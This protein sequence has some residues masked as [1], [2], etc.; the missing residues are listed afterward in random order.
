MR[1]PMTAQS[2]APLLPPL[3]FSG[4]GIVAIPAVDDPVALALLASIIGVAAV[5]CLVDGLREA[6]GRRG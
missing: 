4:P 5:S 6:A 3:L 2:G 1:G